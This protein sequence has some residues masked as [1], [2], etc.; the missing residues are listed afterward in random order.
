MGCLISV[1]ALHPLDFTD[2]ADDGLDAR[3]ERREVSILR[4][5]LQRGVEVEVGVPLCHLGEDLGHGTPAKLP[6]LIGQRGR[7][8]GVKMLQGSNNTLKE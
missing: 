6:G 1:L 2:A 8:I 7:P 4:Q 5:A 3:P